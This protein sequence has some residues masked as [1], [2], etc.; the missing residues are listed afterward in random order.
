MLNA[1][2]AVMSVYGWFAWQAGQSA[3][4][5]LPITERSLTT[6]ALYVIVVV[7]STSIMTWGGVKIL[8][9]SF[10]LWD[11]LSTVLS[12]LGTILLTRRIIST[13]IYLLIADLIYVGIYAASG[14]YLFMG[15]MIIYSVM[16]IVGYSRWQRIRLA[17]RH[18]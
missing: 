13:W 10:A 6:H 8:G 1:F 12:I 4:D 15:M 18:L 17:P 5:E 7:C 3:T 16:A 2:Y 9:T 11:S 14:A